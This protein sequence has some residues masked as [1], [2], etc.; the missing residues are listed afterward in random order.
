[1]QHLLQC[2]RALYGLCKICF[3]TRTGAPQ[4]MLDHSTQIVPC[5]AAPD[6]PAVPAHGTLHAPRPAGRPFHPFSCCSP[7]LGTFPAQPVC[8]Q[9][10]AATAHKRGAT[11]RLVASFAQELRGLSSC[12][13]GAGGR[14]RGSGSRTEPNPNQHWEELQSQLSLFNFQGEMPA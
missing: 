8:A 14:P 4:E 12:R 2:P 10:G 1:M 9:P 11:C 7:S 5:S 13:P 3:P 6:G